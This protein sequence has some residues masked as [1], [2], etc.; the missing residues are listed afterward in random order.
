MGTSSTSLAL[1]DN[2]DSI[3]DIGKHF[4]SFTTTF[5]MANG[6][7]PSPSTDHKE[8]LGPGRLGSFADDSYSAYVGMELSSGPHP[9]GATTAQCA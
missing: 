7:E 1:F 9:L 4:S 3:S 5:I 6:T 2:G 8:E